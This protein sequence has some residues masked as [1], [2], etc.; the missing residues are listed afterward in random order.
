MTVDKT[1]SSKGKQDY[2]TPQDVIVPINLI[3]PLV[4]DLA[5]SKEN[6]VCDGYYSIEDDSLKQD[7]F[8]TWKKYTHGGIRNGYLWLNP[9]YC[10][11]KKK[12]DV[13]TCQKKTCVD[14]GY[15]NQI[16]EPGITKWLEKCQYES[17]RGAKIVT[18]IIADPQVRWYREIVRPNSLSLVITRRIKFVGE[19]TPFTKPNRLCIWGSG[20]IGEGYIDLQ[21]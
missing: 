13:E 2:G 18:L 3:Y 9:P 17:S 20:Q 5:A 14:R 12:C 1:V 15:H 7:W 21:I 11:P 8:R 10:G 16:D 6:T 19:S 4:F